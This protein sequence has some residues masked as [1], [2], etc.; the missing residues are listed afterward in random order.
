[1]NLLEDQQLSPCKTEILDTLSFECNHRK[2]IKVG[3]N[4]SSTTRNIE[5]RVIESYFFSRLFSHFLAR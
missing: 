1:M 4:I 2:L 3:K 5:R